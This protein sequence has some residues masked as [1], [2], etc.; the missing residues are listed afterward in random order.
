MSI[1]ELLEIP[2]R[3]PDQ[4]AAEGPVVDVHLQSIEERNSPPAVEVV[5]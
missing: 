3:E 4:A 2:G 1:A 5:Q